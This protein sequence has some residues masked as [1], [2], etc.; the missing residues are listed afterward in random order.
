MKI[1]PLLFFSLISFTCVRAETPLRVMSFN[2]RYGKANDGENH[3][4]HRRE[5][6]TQVI[7]EFDPDLLGVQESLAFQSEYLME[8][9]E[10]YT[11]FGRS[12]MTTPN[13]HCGIFFNA[14]RFVQLAGGHFWLSETPEVPA[15][16]SWD[17]SLPRMATWLLLQD[18]EDTKPVLIVNTHFDHR[19][20]VAREN[21]GELLAMRIAS[22]RRLT[23]EPR[24]IVTGDFNTDEA[25]AP[26]SALVSDTLVDSYRIAHPE[27]VDGEGTFN[28]WT[29]KTDGARI[30]WILVSEDQHIESASIVRFEREGRY[31][32]DHYPVTA[33]LT[34]R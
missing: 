16:K 19:G 9:L 26:Y 15:S 31:P 30:D 6:V 23:D 1:L 34:G 10:G 7:R 2:I 27:R 18:R 17:S 32:S 11:Y 20:R 12:R 13:E 4:K 3:W 29:G 24:V 28:G 8:N 22:L 33:I 25:T 21:S 5:M 14:S